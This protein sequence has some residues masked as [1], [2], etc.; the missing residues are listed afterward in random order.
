MLA[1][2]IGLHLFGPNA[3]AAEDSNNWRFTFDLVMRWLNFGILA[4]ILIKYSKTPIK[5][6]LTGKKEETARQIN[7]IEQEKEKAEEKIQESLKMLDES[8]VRF[9]ALKQRIIEDGE[10]KKQNIIEEAQ[11]ESKIL[12][13][14]AR[15]KI[16]NRFL[17]AKNSFK[18]E[19]AEM[20]I[21]LAIKRL[22]KEIT[23]NDRQKWVND[24]IANV[25]SK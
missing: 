12:L 14:S 11:Q 2:I 21:A 22:P 15:K 19:L 24:F 8:K 10:K 1:G 13:E 25:T 18:S 7:K 4:F 3:L 23:Q 9:A 6:F 16:D 20:A 5:E 17:E